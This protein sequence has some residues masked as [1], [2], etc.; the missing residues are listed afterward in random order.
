MNTYGITEKSF[1]LLLKTFSK[2]PEIEEVILFG[3][4]A[5]GNYKRGSDID[6]AIKGEYCNKQIAMN[7]NGFVN[8]ELPIPYYVDIISYNGL[9]HDNLKEHVNRIGKI[10]YRKSDQ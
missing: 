4:R 6:L 8:E 9:D 3:S 2:Y 10:L 7:I 1:S 5:K